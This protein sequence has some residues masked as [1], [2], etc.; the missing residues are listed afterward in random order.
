MGA[1][2]P[3]LTLGSSDLGVLLMMLDEPLWGVGV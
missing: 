2:L 3:V 1:H